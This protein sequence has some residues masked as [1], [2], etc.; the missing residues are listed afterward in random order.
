MRLRVRMPLCA[1]GTGGSTYQNGS[2]LINSADSYGATPALAQVATLCMNPFRM[3]GLL[4]GNLLVGGYYTYDCYADSTF[5]PILSSCYSRYRIV[6]GLTLSYAPVCPSTTD[7][8]HTICFTNDCANP[9]IGT[10]AYFDGTYVTESSCRQSINSQ[11]FA[12]WQPWNITF[13][14]DP[15]TEYYVYGPSG[16]SYAP[17]PSE[18]RQQ[19]FGAL[20]CVSNTTAGIGM[21]YTHGLLYVTIDIELRDPSPILGTATGPRLLAGLG[22]FMDKSLTGRAPRVSVKRP[23]EVESKEGKEE[24]KDSSDDDD[25]FSDPSPPHA[26]PLP[27]AAPGGKL[28]APLATP[29]RVSSDKGT[30]AK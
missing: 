7:T 6:N 25:F 30:K 24:K 29:I 10:Q 9:S 16:A 1:I 19:F 3:Y 8:R 2:F 22:S 14:V 18:D 28:Y 5:M 23:L 4:D 13:P 27:S 26:T 20:T 15:R 11:T 17:V 21:A 12:A